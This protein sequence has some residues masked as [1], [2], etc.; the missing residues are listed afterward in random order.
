MV[1]TADNPRTGACAHRASGVRRA[2]P[3]SVTWLTKRRRVAG[4]AGPTVFADKTI[5]RGWY[6]FAPP[7]N[8]VALAPAS[9]ITIRSPSAELEQFLHAVERTFLRRLMLEYAPLERI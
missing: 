6:P 3:F 4:S 2:A 5:S 1:G 8:L 9:T 7:S